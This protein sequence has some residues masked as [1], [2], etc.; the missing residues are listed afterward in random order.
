VCA[1]CKAVFHVATRRPRVEGVCDQCG[2]TLVQ[3]EDDRP[4][5][6]KVRMKAYEDSTRPLIQ[7]YQQRGLLINI[8]ADGT[9][10]EI[11]KR[12]RLLALGH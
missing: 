10:E 1:Q 3:R 9:P 2:G 6:V 5:S 12:T 7:F 11:Y 4:E 8:N